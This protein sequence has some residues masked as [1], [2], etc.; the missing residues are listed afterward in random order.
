VVENH[1]SKLRKLRKIL[2][3][4]LRY[5]PVEVMRESSY[6]IGKSGQRK[7]VFKDEVLM[8]KIRHQGRG[9]DEVVSLGCGVLGQSRGGDLSH[10]QKRESYLL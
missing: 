6:C 2:T 10:W 8:V 3:A 4:I 1:W 9:E 7:F 5:L